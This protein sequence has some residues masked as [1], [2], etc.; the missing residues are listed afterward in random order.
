L[1]QKKKHPG[2]EMYIVLVP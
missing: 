1:E 2:F